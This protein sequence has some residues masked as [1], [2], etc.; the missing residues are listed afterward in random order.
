M[1]KLFA[2]KG[3]SSSLFTQSRSGEMQRLAKNHSSTLENKK[4]NEFRQAYW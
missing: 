1:R 2:R 3:A 4:T